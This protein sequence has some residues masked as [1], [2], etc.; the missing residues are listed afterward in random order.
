MTAET[1]EGKPYN[2]MVDLWYIGMLYYELLVGNPLFKST[3]LT[4]TS[5][6]ILKVDVS[7]PP[8]MPS[9]ART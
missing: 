6:C 9:E 4:E 8:S 2:K 3:S 7:F 1:M 5:K